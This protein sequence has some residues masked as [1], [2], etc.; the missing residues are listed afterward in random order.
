[1]EATVDNPRVGLLALPTAVTDLDADVG[2]GVRDLVLVRWRAV[3]GSNE[4]YIKVFTTPGPDR[5][6]PVVQAGE[7]KTTPHL[8]GE[9]SLT[10]HVGVH[11]SQHAVMQVA[12]KFRRQPIG[13]VRLPQ[14][15]RVGKRVDLPN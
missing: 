13:V 14:L 15:P 4:Q 6:G 9:C 3:G 2:T 10:F 12:V 1:M 5:H 7:T 8:V 11:K